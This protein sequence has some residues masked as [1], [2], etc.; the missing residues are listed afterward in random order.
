MLERLRQIYRSI[1][2][3]FILDEAQVLLVIKHA[4]FDRHSIIREQ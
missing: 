4:K 2:F 3:V 1:T